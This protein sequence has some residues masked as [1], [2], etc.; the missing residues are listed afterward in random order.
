MEYTIREAA[1]LLNLSEREIEDNIRKGMLIAKLDDG[2]WI[3]P[4][5]SI[6]VFRRTKDTLER[7]EVSE[8]SYNQNDREVFETIL[9]EIRNLSDINTLLDSFV[10][11]HLLLQKRVFELEKDLKDAINKI[12]ELQLTVVQ[13]REDH[14]QEI[15]L[16]KEQIEKLKM[17]V[18]DVLMEKVD[19][20]SNRVDDIE[21]RIEG[22]N[23]D[24][25]VSSV[26]LKI[27]TSH[28]VNVHKEGFWSRFL[29][30]LTWD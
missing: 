15:L 29:R 17:Q 22:N 14:K 30:M 28:S 16:L 27:E 6:R 24:S 9:K 10:E 13:S 20:I 26:P 18:N 4:E 21:G 1:E 3:I 23:T 11:L 12:S 5:W 2:E 25:P 8:G 19:S 7:I